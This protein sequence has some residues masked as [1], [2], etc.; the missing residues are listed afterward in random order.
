MIYETIVFFCIV[1]CNESKTF[2]YGIG[3]DSYF[4]IESE[5]EGRDTHNLLVRARI[6][7][8]YSRS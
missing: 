8:S 3:C 4:Y 2:L 7:N 6:I 5:P 1:V